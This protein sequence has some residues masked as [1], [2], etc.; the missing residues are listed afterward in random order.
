MSMAPFLTAP[1]NSFNASHQ[2]PQTK[3]LGLVIIRS[4]FQSQ[5]FIYFLI[6]SGQHDD[7]NT[8]SS[9]LSLDSAAHF[10]TIHAWKH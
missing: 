7:R 9:L 3:W 8:G 6:F 4:Q 2:F 5:N 10:Q 1:Q